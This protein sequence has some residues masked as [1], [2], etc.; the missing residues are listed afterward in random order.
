MYGSSVAPTIDMAASA[1]S[2]SA[3][4]AGFLPHE[5]MAPFVAMS[6]II[7]LFGIFPSPN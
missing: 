3:G 2:S 6:Y 7:S 4:G 5:N 1:I